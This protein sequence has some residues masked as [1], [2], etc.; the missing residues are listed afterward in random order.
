VNGSRITHI[1]LVHQPLDIRIFRKQCRALAAAGWEVHLVVPGPPAERIDGVRLHA[2]SDDSERPAARDQWARQWRAARWAWRLRPSTY[3]LHEPHLIPL[4]L[5]LKLAGA[6]IVYDV[7]EH[8][9]DH[10]RS[11]L[12]RHPVRRRL[13]ALLWTVLEGVARRAF[14]RFVCAS[15]SLGERFPS[16][17]TE[18]VGNFPL[19]DAFGELVPYRERPACVLYVGVMREIRA[20]WEMVRAVD[21]VSGDL[22]WQLRMI[23]PMRWHELGGRPRPIPG[24][25]NIE[26]LPRTPHPEVVREMLSA[27]VGLALLYPLP[28]HD[29]AIRSNKLFEYMA[30]GVPV[31]ASDLPS[32][33][34]IVC[35]VGCGLV[36]DPHDPAAIAGAIERLLRDP[37]EAEAM[38]RRGRA[39]VESTFNWDGEAARL[40]ALY[41]GLGDRNGWPQAARAPVTERA[42]SS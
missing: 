17:R 40:L 25:R 15:P 32:W 4:G 9:P 14:D 31:I 38:G 37:E 29:D 34:G 19:V 36:V 20:F 39:A 13:K 35:G 16:A 27:R 28:N 23:G 5:A 26:V 3:H 6:R 22:D 2:V 24:R 8:N 18:V 30:A 1:A 41:D 7:H 33:R 10:A 11:K 21:L 12:M 42:S